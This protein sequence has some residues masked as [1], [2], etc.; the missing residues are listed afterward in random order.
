MTRYTGNQVSVSSFPSLFYVPRGEEGGK[1]PSYVAR[2]H[3][4]HVLTT[5]TFFS[6]LFLSYARMGGR[7]GRTKES[8]PPYIL[9]HEVAFLI[10][11]ATKSHQIWTYLKSA[12]PVFC[13]A[14]YLQNRM[15]KE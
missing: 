11:G 1:G 8:F 15:H 12:F 10:F 13:Q 14:P 3:L 5:M 2:E 6:S 9:L 4:V 7:Y